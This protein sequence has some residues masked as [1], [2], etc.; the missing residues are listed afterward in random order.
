MPDGSLEEPTELRLVIRPDGRLEVESELGSDP[1]DSICTVHVEAT[2][3]TKNGGWS[4]NRP[5]Q[6]KEN[7]WL[8]RLRTSVI[9]AAVHLC[10]LIKSKSTSNLCCVFYEILD[11]Y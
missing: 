6:D 4:Q 10:L 8:E 7:G 5:E 9:H 11:V 2:L 3:V 1:E